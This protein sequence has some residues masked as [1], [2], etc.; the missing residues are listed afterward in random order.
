[1]NTVGQPPWLASDC[2]CLYL[3][4]LDGASFSGGHEAPVPVSS[5]PGTFLHYKVP[6]RRPINS[7]VVAVGTAG[8]CSAFR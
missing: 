8:A 6:S 4:Y 7:A 1:M 2:N 5:K 3:P